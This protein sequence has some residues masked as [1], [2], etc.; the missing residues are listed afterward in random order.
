M[1]IEM[2]LMTKLEKTISE[3]FYTLEIL[4][5]SCEQN[6]K[7]AYS[8]LISEI[9]GKQTFIFNILDELFKL[10]MKKEV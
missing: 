4:K 6:E 9:T 5:D 8:F 10:N 7:F 2:E 1:K 3:I